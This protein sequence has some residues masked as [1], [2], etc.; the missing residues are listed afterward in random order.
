MS[1]PPSDIADAR[2]LFSPDPGREPSTD[3]PAPAD[4]PLSTIAN[5]PE[6]SPQPL[7]PVS[8]P[9]LI[10]EVPALSRARRALYRSVAEDEL[11]SDV[12]YSHDNIDGVVGETEYEGVR[13]MWVRYRSGI[14]HKVCKPPVPVRNPVD[15]LFMVR[16]HFVEGT[17]GLPGVLF[18]YSCR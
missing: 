6:G 10:V 16:D 5:S 14:I 2:L 4:S 12:E 3:A 18:L 13:F 1:D 7:P 17:N 9:P 11:D 8:M 15:L